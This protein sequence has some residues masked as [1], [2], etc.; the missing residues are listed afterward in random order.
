MNHEA[1]PANLRWGREVTS[2]PIG[3]GHGP[4]CSRT[5]ARE[6][7]RIQD[8]PMARVAAI[9]LA[10]GESRRLGQ[11][12]QLVDLCGRP[13]LAYVLDVVRRARFA[14]RILVL[15]RLAGQIQEVVDC[16]GFEVVVSERATEGQSFSLRA[17][18]AALPPE[19]DAVVFL[20]G[21][22]PFVDPMVIERLLDAFEQRRSSIVQPRYR[23]GPGNPVLIARDL[24]EEL[25]ALE[26]DTGARPVLARYRH[27][28][29]YV[30]VPELPAPL[31]LDTPE[32]VERARRGCGER[33]RRP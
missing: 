4:E 14:N 3:L 17:G 21:D 33:N 8:I 2:S 16:S 32:D 28:I 20:L 19:I 22:Q 10:A 29:D 12:K 5:E 24:F 15:G 6:F 31:D 27:V 25:R 1:V 18:L 9:V 26:G 23:N 11:P 13:A 30:E 7:E